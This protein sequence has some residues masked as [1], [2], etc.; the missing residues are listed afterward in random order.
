MREEG[1]KEKV[2]LP[3][4]QGGRETK[5]FQEEGVKDPDPA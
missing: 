3:K 1:E 4:G 5:F 2:S